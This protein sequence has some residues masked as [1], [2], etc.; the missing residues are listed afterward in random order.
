M[1]NAITIENLVKKYKV[2]QNETLA[3][4]NIA[5]DVSEGDLFAFLGPNG[6]GKSTTINIICTLLNKDM[7]NI[8]VNGYDIEHEPQRVRQSI[9]V[10]FQENI[11]DE[12]LTVKENL[13]IR[14]SLYTSNKKVLND[15][16]A[17]LAD[18]LS[19]GDIMDKRF[20]KLSGGQKRRAEV[21][22]ALMNDPKLLILDEPT[23]GLDPQTRINVWETISDLKTKLGMTVFLTTHYMEEA[24]NADMVAV[25][26][27][28]KIVAMGTPA[29]LKEKHSHDTVKL[30]M[31]NSAD[32]K[33]VRVSDSKAALSVISEHEGLYNSFEVLQGTM[34]DVFINI[35]GRS[36]RE[37]A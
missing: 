22:R 31:K 11:L 33:T 23:T 28:G 10:V 34:D 24:A 16:F 26:D 32:V 6:A 3:V 29:E 14:G 13:Y 36:I 2:G 15:R 9:G 12:L 20:G 7:G 17:L 21:A 4:N 37:G 8:R 1:P 5:F 19:I 30:Y 27:Y 35:T 18:A 25:I